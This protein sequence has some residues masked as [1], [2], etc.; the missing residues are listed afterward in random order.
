MP[1]HPTISPIDRASKDRPFRACVKSLRIKQRPLV[2]ITEQANSCLINHQVEAFAR[3]GTIS[4]DVA[5]TE[6]L[7]HALPARVG[8][9]RLKRFHVA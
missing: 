4:D 7:F 8:Q 3:I 1:D 6:N 2:V 5:Q 9:H